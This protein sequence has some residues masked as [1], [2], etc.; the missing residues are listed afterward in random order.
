[1]IKRAL[2]YECVNNIVKHFE[3][4][5]TSDPM[6]F[7]TIEKVS[8]GYASFMILDIERIIFKRY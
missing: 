6:E 7:G 2:T 1:M 3:L 5:V 4:G 8:S